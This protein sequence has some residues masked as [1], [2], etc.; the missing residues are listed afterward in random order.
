MSVLTALLAGLRDRERAQVVEAIKRNHAAQLDSLDEP[1][2]RRQRDPDGV[3]RW[4]HRT[5]ERENG[6]S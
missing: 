1:P 4:R 5:A 2:R 6:Q 3:L